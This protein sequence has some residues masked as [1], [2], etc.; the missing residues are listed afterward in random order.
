METNTL[1]KTSGTFIAVKDDLRLDPEISLRTNF[2]AEGVEGA[3]V[4]ISDELKCSGD[5]ATS[6][7]PS[8]NSAVSDLEIRTQYISVDEN[9]T[10][11]SSNV[12][13]DIGK[14]LFTDTIGSTTGGVQRVAVIG[15]GISLAG[16][17]VAQGSVSCSDVSTAT[18]LSLSDDISDLQSLKLSRNGTQAMNGNLNMGGFSVTNATDVLTTLLKTN[19]I[20]PNDDVDPDNISVIVPTINYNVSFANFNGRPDEEIEQRYT[21]QGSNWGTI[22]TDADSFFLSNFGNTAVDIA[23]RGTGG[24]QLR[25]VDDESKIQLTGLDLDMDNN[26][27]LNCPSINGIQPSGGLYSESSGFTILAAN[28]AETDLL[29]QGSSAGSLSIPANGFQPLSMYSFKAS[30]QLS[31]GANDAFTLRAKT[32]TD[33]PSTVL[34]GEIAVELNDNGIVGLWWDIAIDFSIRTTGI[35]GVAVIV[36]SGVFRYT[37]NSDVVK[38]FGRNIVLSSGFDTTV[39]NALSLS[40]Q[41]DATNPLTSFRIDQASFTKWF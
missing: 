25:I 36:L 37:N 5:I 31:G 35:A 12:Q 23:L 6:T 26:Q 20:R 27:I 8:V 21:R 3:G 1:Q 22:G 33:I 40:F 2:I 14:T 34:L 38:S 29:G 15:Q 4:T 28:L 19:Q 24:R 13:V 7:V 11:F 17:V 10:S 39:S 32:T 16:E 41:N 9:E 18:S 30:G